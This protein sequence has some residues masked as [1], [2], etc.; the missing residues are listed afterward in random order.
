M[1]P[2]KEQ[3][4]FHEGFSGIPY[5]DTEGYWTIGYG[6]FLGTKKTL[7]RISKEDAERLLDADLAVAVDEVSLFSF[8][9]KLSDNQKNVLVD[10]AFNLG[11]FKLKSFKNM[12]KAAEVGDNREFRRQMFWTKIPGGIV[13]TRY[14]RQVKKRAIRLA[15]MWKHDMSFSEV[16]NRW[17]F[18]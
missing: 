2:D 5:K 14:S 9:D 3:I 10:M 18:I 6:H 13:R 4:K 11:I 15:L 17:R 8:W 1:V 16:R 12:L 7:K